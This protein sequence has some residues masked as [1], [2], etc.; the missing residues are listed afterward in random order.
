MEVLY[1]IPDKI[2]Q[3]YVATYY[4]GITIVESLMRN[5]LQEILRSQGQTARFVMFSVRF[6]ILYCFLPAVALAA[7]DF[8]VTGITLAPA[9]PVANSTFSARVTVRNQGTTAGNGKQV[10]VWLDETAVQGCG[11]SGDSSV[12]LGVLGVGESSTLTV[13]GLA[14]GPTG[15]KTLRVFVDNT[16]LTAEA[17]ES[18]NQR[19][20]TYTVTPPLRPDFVVSSIVLTPASPAPNSTFSARVTVRNQGS[21][22][23]DGRQ[24]TVWANRVA[25]Q[26]CGASGDRSVAVG[27]LAPGLSTTLTVNGLSAG[28]AGAKTLRAFVDGTCATTESDETNNQGVHGYTVA[29]AD[30]VVGNITLS[31]TSPTPNGTFNALVTVNNQ[32]T[33][34][35]SGGQLMVWPNQSAAQSCGASG[36]RSVTVGTLA[37]GGSAV[38]T[39]NGLAAGAPGAKT[40][41]AF[42]DSACATTESNE[43]NNQT[44]KTYTVAGRADFV[45]TGVT[46]TPTAPAQNGT[47][48]VLVTIRNQGTASGNSGQLTVWA[49]R[50]AAQTCGASGDQS[51]TVGTLAAGASTTLTVSN[52]PAGSAGAK[53]LRAFV[54]GTC[55][56]TEANED[57]N[58]LTQ[59]YTVSAPVTLA[60]LNDTGITT[61]SNSSQNGLACPV[62]GFSGQ[63]AQVGRDAN[64]ATNSATDG[65]AGFSFTKLDANG[66]TLAAS[67][68]NWSCVKD[69]VTGLIWEVKTNDGGL[70]DKDNTYTW[71]NPNANT[72]GGNA[73]TSDGGTCTGGGYCDTDGFVQAVNAQGWCGHNDWRMPTVREL[74]GIA[75]LDGRSPA[76]DS[77]FFPNT[78]ASNFWSGS[79]VAG[80]SNNAWYVYFNYGDDNWSF[81]NNLFA[82]RLVRAG[83]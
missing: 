59:S 26:T 37:A 2:N 28:V 14:A 75:D 39:V 38:L 49:D 36:G 51:A 52:L 27:A 65:H 48:S 11:A 30:F 8:L 5:L 32:G 82:V 68:A 12:A 6:L 9:S 19:T 80:F 79:P 35:G 71:Y 24:L 57:N 67:A 4:F 56:T 73:G 1:S 78:N 34:A 13:T 7:P 20:Q 83:Q 54:D 50:A 58:Q 60:R 16:C 44:T 64:S 40:L 43:A 81:R 70:H 77:N 61:C 17:N 47:F 66:N 53:T 22:A 23:G 74:R 63:D 29:A 55:V 33:G 46:L 76:I 45:V 69:N 10:A 18:N 3:P 15:T 25:A 21:A 42:V 41:R 62:G 72:N 31:P